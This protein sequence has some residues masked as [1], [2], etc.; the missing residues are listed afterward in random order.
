M[1]HGARERP[2]TAALQQQGADAI[3]MR[4]ALCWWRGGRTEQM[5]HRCETKPVAGEK[6]DPRFA[7]INYTAGWD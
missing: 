3:S 6:V 5:I 4:G 2:A 1:L 7:H